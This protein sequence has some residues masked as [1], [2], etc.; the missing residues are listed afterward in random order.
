MQTH[1]LPDP[2]QNFAESLLSSCS[3]T[4]AV[5]QIVN[6]QRSAHWLAAAAVLVHCG[7]GASRSATL[8]IA[9]LMKSR[10]W[11]AEQARQHCVALRSVVAPNPGFWRAL[12]GYEQELGLSERCD[13]TPGSA[14]MAIR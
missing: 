11:S 6:K 12:C 5:P 14:E 13:R 3:S 8:C 7:A 9:Y 10:G 1:S 4:L 2:G